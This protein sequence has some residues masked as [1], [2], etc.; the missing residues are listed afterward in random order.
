[1]DIKKWMNTNKLK[2][3]DDKTEILHIRSRFSRSQNHIQSLS[4][5]D[6][7]I[8]PVDYARNIG[9]G[10]DSTHEFKQHIIRLCKCIY[11]DIRR[12]G[13]IRKYLSQQTCLKLV[14]ATLSSK[15]DYANAL[16]FGLPSSSINLLQRAQNSAARLIAQVKKHEHISPILMKFHWLPVIYRI[17]FKILL[18][19]YKALNGTAPDY[20]T[21]LIELNKPT[22][23]LRSSDKVSLKTP[24]TRLR[25]YGDCSFSYAA[26]TL[27]NDLPSHIRSAS[28]TEIFK[29]RLKTYFFE[30][31]Y[32]K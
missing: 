26:A 3:N 20:L 24:R 9:F 28:S 16:L 18:L 6:S 27:W 30:R 4:V 12:I 10:F 29:C 15:L 13:F 17:K 14:N 25:F 21:T 5:G 11:F 19:T 1:M 7:T 2:L 22:R 32:L 23:S 31:A 8:H